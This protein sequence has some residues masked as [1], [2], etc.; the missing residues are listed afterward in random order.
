VWRMISK[1]RL[2]FMLIDRLRGG[3]DHVEPAGEAK[4][5]AHESMHVYLRLAQVGTLENSLLFCIGI[6]SASSVGRCRAA[7]CFCGAI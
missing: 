4:A 1:V 2:S 7:A 6:D 3:T 5:W